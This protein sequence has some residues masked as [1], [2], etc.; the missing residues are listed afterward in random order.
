[1]KGNTGVG[2]GESNDLL[3][4]RFRDLYILLLLIIRDLLLHLIL[5][6]YERLSFRVMVSAF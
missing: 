5:T 3:S 6:I 4:F 1:M 2:G